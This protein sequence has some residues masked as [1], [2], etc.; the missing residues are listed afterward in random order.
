MRTSAEKNFSRSARIVKEISLASDRAL[1]ARNFAP[2]ARSGA[3]ALE[4][5]VSDRNFSRP[6]KV[7][8]DRDACARNFFGSSEK[9]FYD[10]S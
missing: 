9:K 6:I 3:P 7:F 5:I 10:R 2:I 1:H 8:S 4:A